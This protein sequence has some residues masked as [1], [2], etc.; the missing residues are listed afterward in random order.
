[1]FELIAGIFIVG[2]LILASNDALDDHNGVLKNNDSFCVIEQSKTDNKIK[3]KLT[4]CKD[5]TET[6]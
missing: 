2:G 3:Y 5:S 4:N 1:M 6:Q